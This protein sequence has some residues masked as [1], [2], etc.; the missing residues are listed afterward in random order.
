M[1]IICFIRGLVSLPPAVVFCRAGLPHDPPPLTMISTCE[2]RL[3]SCTPQP[4]WPSMLEREPYTSVMGASGGRE[5]SRRSRGL[6]A[7]P[8]GSVMF[9]K[10]VSPL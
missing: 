3:I 10:A 1:M 2:P 5:P 9:L 6:L 7:Q 4:E 8:Y